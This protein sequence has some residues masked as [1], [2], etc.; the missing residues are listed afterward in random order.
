MARGDKSKEL[1]QLLK[2][3]VTVLLDT[4][5]RHGKELLNVK[6]KQ[7]IFMPQITATETDIPEHQEPHE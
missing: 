6:W 7:L 2:D 5:A 3:C 1:R 4:G